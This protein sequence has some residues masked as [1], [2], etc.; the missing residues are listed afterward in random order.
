MSRERVRSGALEEGVELVASRHERERDRDD[1][2]DLRRR[3]DR[4]KRSCLPELT[5]DSSHARHPRDR[6]P[7]GHAFGNGLSTPSSRRRGRGGTREGDSLPLRMSYGFET[8]AAIFA[9]R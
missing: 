1:R 9:I 8:A 7:V 4:H 5:N 6:T 2:H 3:H